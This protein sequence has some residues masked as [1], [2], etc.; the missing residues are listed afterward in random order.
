MP[1]DDPDG[2]ADDRMRWHLRGA[3]EGM[4]AGID[5]AEGCV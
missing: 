3:A 1:N 5:P 4:R 2:L